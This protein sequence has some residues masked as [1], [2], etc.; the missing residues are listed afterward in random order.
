MEEAKLKAKY[1]Q[2]VK[3]AAGHSMFLQKRLTKGVSE[4]LR[5][6]FSKYS[7]SWFM[8]LCPSS[9][10]KNSLT[11]ETIRCTS[12]KGSWGSTNSVERAWIQL[13]HSPLGRPSQPPRPYLPGRPP[14]SSTQSL[15]QSPHQHEHVII[16]D[17]K[18]PSFSAVDGLFLDD[19]NYCR[20]RHLGSPVCFIVMCSM[21]PFFMIVNVW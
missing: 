4:V 6:G 5:W 2:T 17:V 21:N 20:Y 1:P 8:H 11:L 14:S 18:G 12:S 7:S 3:P 16:C 9:N 10:S 13:W 19:P 15:I